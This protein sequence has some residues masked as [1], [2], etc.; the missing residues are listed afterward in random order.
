MKNNMK[1]P[2]F[3]VLTMLLFGCSS[4]NAENCTKTIT[5]QQIYVINNQSYYYDV[6]QEVPCDFPDPESLVQIDPPAL[7][8]FS[9]EVLNFNFTPDTGNNTS[10]L[11]F[12]IKLNNP[13]DYNAVGVPILT[14]NIGGLVST[15]SYSNNASI[16]CYQINAN[17]S[18]I[19]TFDQES[20]LDLGIINSIELVSVEYF[21][22]N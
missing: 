7:E 3:F 19:L 22:T 2:L 17:S 6:P 9:Y 5:L 10:R 11:Q 13:N 16:P 21:L 1:S 20:S 4:D 15:G 12:E 14:I 8:K 18:C